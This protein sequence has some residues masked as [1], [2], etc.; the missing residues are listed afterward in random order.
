LTRRCDVPLSFSF[1]AL[2]NCFR[3]TRRGEVPLSFSFFALCNCF[4]FTRRGE[5]PLSF[6]F[7]ALRNC[8]VPLEHRNNGDDQ[9]NER[10]DTHQAPGNRVPTPEAKV[11]PY[12][13][14]RCC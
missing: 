8:F 4:R 1:F 7:F 6:S 14:K 9:E 10:G 3:F 2:C 13:L 12:T 11:P 5:V